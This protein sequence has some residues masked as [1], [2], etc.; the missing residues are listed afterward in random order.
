M[1]LM[2]IPAGGFIM[3]SPET[4][5]HRLADEKQVLVSL[6]ETFWMAAY[7]CTQHQW[8]TVMG[9]NPSYFEGPHRPVENVSWSDA[10]DFCAKITENEHASGKLPK[11]LCYALPTEA[12]WEYAC[13]AGT[14]TP[15][16]IGDG[17][18]PWFNAGK[19]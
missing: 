17:N 10:I 19:L 15:F 14:T 5:K 7:Q 18:N 11:D 3:G 1:I 8:E 9:S 2:P 4:E 16:G 13:R 12:Q 6:T